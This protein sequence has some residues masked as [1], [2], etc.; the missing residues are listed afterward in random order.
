LYILINSKNNDDLNKHVESK[1]QL[2]KS[3]IKEN[4]EKLMFK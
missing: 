2:D 4:I 1:V 3:K